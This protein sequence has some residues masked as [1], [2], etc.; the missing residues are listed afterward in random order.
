MFKYLTPFNKICITI[1]NFT[2]LKS[3]CCISH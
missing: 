1:T 3:I 2:N